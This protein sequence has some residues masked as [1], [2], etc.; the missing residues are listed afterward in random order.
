MRLKAKVLLRVELDGMLA[1][2]PRAVTKERMPSL[3]RA[4]WATTVV[5]G[6]VASRSRG[7]RARRRSARWRVQDARGP[8][9]STRT[10]ISLVRPPWERSMH[11]SADPLFACN[12]M[13]VDANAGE[14]HPRRDHGTHRS[15]V[16]GHRLNVST[17]VT[18]RS[19]AFTRFLEITGHQLGCR[20]RRTGGIHSVPASA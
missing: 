11:G 15:I 5:P 16:G 10:W 20:R 9:A 14:R 2:A 13:P 3:P 17:V 4:F 6:A 7:K 18:I 1:Q 8:A 19:L 12:S